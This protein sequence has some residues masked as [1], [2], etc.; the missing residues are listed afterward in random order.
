M[1][2][3]LIDD[4]GHF[5]AGGVGVASGEEIIYYAPPAERVPQLMK[6]LFILSEQLSTLI[7][8][9]NACNNTTTLPTGQTLSDAL[10]E[11]DKLM[12]DR[13]IL[14]SIAAKAVEKDYRLT[15]AEVK[16]SVTVSVEELQKQVDALS[17]QFRALDTLIQ[18]INWTTELE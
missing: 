1:E 15:H 11:R 10:V 4:A 13:N 18:G 3:G 7:K 12:K 8:K 17:Q 9:I 16:M 14:A 6:E 2:T 5:R